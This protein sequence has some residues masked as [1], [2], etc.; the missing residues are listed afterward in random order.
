[1]RKSVAELDLKG[2]IYLQLFCRCFN[3]FAGTYFI[4]GYCVVVVACPA[5]GFFVSIEHFDKLGL[6]LQFLY[7]FVTVF[8]VILI[9]VIVPQDAKVGIDSA[10]YL[11]GLSAKY[12]KRSKNVSNCGIELVGKPTANGEI[13]KKFIRKRIRA[14]LPV[15]IEIWFFGP[16]TI[17]TTQ[18]MI[19]QLFNNTL[20][21]LS[22]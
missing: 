8:C 22:L 14:F 11:A 5:L 4:T 20:L 15:G 6:Q 18:N 13:R 1:M 10:N 19:D 3:D 21:L 16:H 9:V 7:P 17:A 2:Y 12:I